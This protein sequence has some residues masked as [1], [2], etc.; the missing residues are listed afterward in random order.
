[1]DMLKESERQLAEIYSPYLLQA[2]KVPHTF[3]LKRAL[4]W[5]TSLE[6]LF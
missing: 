4:I 5:S 2:D 3:L 6:C 1:M